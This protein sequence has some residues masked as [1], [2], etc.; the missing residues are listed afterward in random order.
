MTEPN[1]SQGEVEFRGSLI[2]PSETEQRQV[3]LR[4]D[5]ESNAV[6]IHFDGEIAGATAWHG[7]SLRVADRPKYTEVVFLTT[8][9]PKETV[10]LTWKLNAAYA[11]GTLVGVIVPKKNTQKVSGEKG[12]TLVRV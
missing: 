6:A 4:L 11:D 10:Q 7:S 5:R 8:D 1:E 3:S 9:L 12:F 2:I